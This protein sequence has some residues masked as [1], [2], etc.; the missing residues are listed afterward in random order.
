[1]HWLPVG[2]NKG[3]QNKGVC[4]TEAAKVFYCDNIISNTSTCLRYRVLT[5]PKE[6]GKLTAGSFCLIGDKLSQ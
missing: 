4:R 5:L 6:A 3:L 2:V 1:M